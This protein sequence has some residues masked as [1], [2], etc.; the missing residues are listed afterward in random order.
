MKA[1]TTNQVRRLII[2]DVRGVTLTNSRLDRPYSLKTVRRQVENHFF[3]LNN[4]DVD[5]HGTVL[6]LVCGV[7][8]KRPRK[9]KTTP[10]A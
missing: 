3:V 10:T 7:R 1:I 8:D 6:A 5:C 9:R 2:E 4:V